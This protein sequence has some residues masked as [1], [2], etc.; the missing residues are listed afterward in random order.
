VERSG[1]FG[2][3]RLGLRTRIALL[4]AFGAALLAVVLSTVTYILVRSALIEQRESRAIDIAYAN[5]RLVQQALQSNPT[6]V[7]PILTSLPSPGSSRPLV[8]YRG[9][10][11][12]LTSEYGRDS[13]PESLRTR[14]V[15]DGVP[16]MMLSRL[17]GDAVLVVGIPMP[18]VGA[19]YFELGDLSDIDDTLSSVAVSLAGASVLTIGLGAVLGTVAARRAVKPLADAAQAA[20]AIAGG[21][22]DTRLEDVDDPDLGALAVAF[23]DMVTALQTRVE[24][25]ARFASDVSHELRSPLMT[26]SAS[27]EVLASRRE[28]MPEKAQAA[29]D[30]LV[31]DV[32]RFKGLVEDLLEISRVDAGAVRL[33]LEEFGV[34]EFVRAALS[35]SSVRDAT[36][37]TTPL[38][39]QMVINGDKRR[40]ARVVANLVDNARLHGGGDVEVTVTEPPDEASPS[41]IWIAVEDHG[42]GV[43]PEERH[44]VFERFARGSAAGRR[45]V[46]EGSGL[47][48]ALV[49]EHVR[50]HGGRVWVEDRADGQAGARFVIEL[51]AEVVE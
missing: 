34:A 7:Q 45:S 16:A 12:A 11:T 19:A 36:L 10:W 49:D 2:W 13:V 35:I 29:L 23:N 27:A 40:L 51:P 6:S 1:P 20:R 26:L 30:L 37:V 44:L 28:D 17:G 9:E 33:H 18:T 46:T 48:L 24:R 38:A 32:N 42:P 5:G 39:E 41:T 8:F 25:D 47:G 21:H 15:D 31:A 50:L 22:L 43:P 4:F 14:V 3:G